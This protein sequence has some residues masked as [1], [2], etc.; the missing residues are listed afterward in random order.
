M[1]ALTTPRHMAPP[2]ER[3]FWFSRQWETNSTW[4][5]RVSAMEFS[6]AR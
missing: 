2:S 1:A 3:V 6:S 5:L 4:P